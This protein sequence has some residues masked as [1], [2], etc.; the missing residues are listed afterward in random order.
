MASLVW[1]TKEGRLF[2]KVGG[3]I[4][5]VLMLIFFFIK[6]GELIQ[7]LF[8]PKPPPEPLQ[9]HGKLPFIIFPEQNAQTI[10]YTINTLD[11]QIPTLVDRINVYKI[12]SNKPS[13]L[14][15]KNAKNTLDSANFVESQTKI[16]DTLYR[17]TQARTGVVIEYDIVTKNF[18]IFSDFLQNNTLSSQSLLPD[19]KSIAS[20]VYSFLQT[21]NADIDNIDLEK[22][23]VEMLELKNG[24]LVAAQNLGTA[25]YARA[26]FSHIPVDE[27]NT[28]FG[29]PGG[30]QLTF[31]ASYPS[32][33]LQ[34]LEGQFIN[35]IA[36]LDA[37]SDYP[38]KS[39][40]AAFE[41]LKKGNG[42][43]INPQNL[44]NVDITN[45][46]VKYYLTNKNQGYL[47]PVI[48][49]TGINFTAY[50]QAIPDTSLASN[51]G[52]EQNLPSQ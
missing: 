4:F 10:Q 37:K 52:E 26:T 50:V 49:F 44:T 8:F 25:R 1:V 42:Y 48:V 15:L 31:I 28:V 27:I 46:E 43:I 12:K 40:E 34:V 51:L 2:L 38:I 33:N 47:L 45:V 14:A 17:F 30:S 18:T 21:I 39:A 35:H 7:N 29:A 32:S 6:G 20:D 24:G 5:G 36:D 23:K 9:A 16:T 41:D 3:I 13:L 19:E 22:T 11:G